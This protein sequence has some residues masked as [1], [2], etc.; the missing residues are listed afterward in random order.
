VAVGHAAAAAILTLRAQDGAQTLLVGDPAYRQG[1]LP[2]E[3]RFTPGT[4]FAFAPRLGELTP[5]VLSDGSQFRPGPPHPVTDPRYTADFDE[6]KRLGGD[7]ATT[8]SAR[9]ADQTEIALFWVESSPLQWNRIAR[10]VS[11]GARLDMWEKARLFGLLNM[12]LTDGYI[13]S[14]ETKYHYNYWRPVTAIREAATDGNPGTAAD[15]TWTPLVETPPIP[16][17]DSG[18]AVEGGAAAEVLRRFFGTDHIGF[19]TCSTTLPKGSQCGDA[20]SVSRAYSSFSQAAD[21]NGLS[22]ILVGFH[23]REAVEVGIAHGARVGRRAVGLFLQPVRDRHDGGGQ[24]GEAVLDWNKHALDALANAPTA[25]TPGAGMAAPVQGVHLAMVQGAVYD[26]VNS[27]A[28]GYESYLDVH[29]APSSASQAAATATAAHDVLVAVLNQAPLTAT[30]TAA[31]RQAIIDRLDLLEGDSIADA[32]ATDG[33][34]SV[35][36]GVDAGEAAAAAMIAARAGD[37]RWGP[38]RFTCGEEPGQWRPSTSLECTTPSGPSDPF[39]W[40]AKVE[41]FVVE[42]NE[43]FLSGGPPALNTGAYA[44]QYDEVKT[45]G[46][47]GS[48]RTSEQ[49]ALVDFFQANPVEMYNRSFR[50]HALAGGLDLAEQARLFAKFALASGDTFINCWESKAHWSNWRPQTAIRLGDE[51]GNR[52]TDGDPTWTPALATPPYPDV[53]SGYNCTTGSYMKIADLYFGQRRTTFTL[54]HPTGM[55]REYRH[56]RDVVDDTVDA[57]VYQGLHFRFADELGAKLGRDVARWVEKHA[58]Q[59]VR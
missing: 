18:H 50:A 45:L 55:T 8:P 15:P 34:A 5:F 22:R 42:S 59:R 17:Y 19:S 16:D 40:V 58:L 32:T 30:F 56:F 1:I 46:A 41:P 43:Q 54:A 37:G 33:A 28:G 4:P 24:D 47:Q 52:K 51:D 6:V 36:D 49:Q 26:A 39:A 38:F 10:T 9:T 7:V 31:V 20:A 57:R 3:Y 11:A 53:A 21:E 35:A 48:A 27:I 25:A 14:F 12:A 23:F 29:A 2:G 44:K 13:G